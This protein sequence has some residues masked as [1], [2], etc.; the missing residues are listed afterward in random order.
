M[1]EGVDPVTELPGRCRG[2]H[3]YSPEKQAGKSYCKW[4]GILE[5]RDCFDPLFFNISPRE[6]ES[7][8]PHQRLILQESWRALEDAGYNPKSLSE[9][10][11]GI[12]V[13][14]EPSAYLHETFTGASDA[15]VASRLSYFLNLSG[16]ALVVNT[17][18]SSSGVALHLAC[19][20]LRNNESD[21]A[22]AGG[23]FAVMGEGI[24]VGLSQTEMLSRNGR[25]R[26]F[27]ADADGM[28]MS[29]GVGMVALKRLDEALSDGDA[30]YGVIRASG[31]NQDGDRKS[32][33]LNSS[34]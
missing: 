27:D 32:T 31:I 16:P 22:L 29:E 3:S 20:S 10:R 11:T 2:R 17:G 4:G 5:T 30:I 9:S 6:A 14:C 19:E 33:R 1:I 15:I 23:V 26:S 13:G 8:N 21:L 28:V 34:H 18:C 12:F 25:C 24:L 7:M